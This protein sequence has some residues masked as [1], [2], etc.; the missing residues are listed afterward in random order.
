MLRMRN[1]LYTAQ[2]LAMNALPR[3][4]C[5]R[6]AEQPAWAT[7]TNNEEQT[8]SSDSDTNNKADEL[9]ELVRAREA[10]KTGHA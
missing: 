3:S 2:R 9:M 8:M 4:G 10:K 1:L 6:L 5:E 7:G